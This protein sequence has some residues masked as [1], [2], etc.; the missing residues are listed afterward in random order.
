MFVGV[1]FDMSIRCVY[2]VKIDRLEYKAQYIAASLFTQV[3][4][5][6]ATIHVNKVA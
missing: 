4:T 1:V 3:Y 5:Y 2:I 6:I